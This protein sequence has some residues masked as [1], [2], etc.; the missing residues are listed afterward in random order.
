[1]TEKAPHPVLLAAILSLGAAISLGITRFAYGLLL[2]MMREDLG[3][4]YALAGAMNTANA[5]GYLLGA[6]GAPALL[7]RTGPARLLLW[8]AVLATLF[9]ASSGFF[10][11]PFPL[12]VQRLLAGVASAWVFVAGGLLVARLAARH[13][14]RSGWLLGLYYGG[15][16]WGIVA[17]SWLVPQALHRGGH[18]AHAWWWL[19]LSCA[20]ATGVLWQPLRRLHE[21]PAAAAASAHA[22]R[23]VPWQRYAPALA[24]YA[25][26]GIG[27]IGYMTFV[28][29]MLREH[30]VGE[31]GLTGFYACLG[32]A[33][34][35]SSRIWAG[36]LD[37]CREGQALALLNALLGLATIVPALTSHPLA[38]LLSGL[39]FG[40]VFL[41]VVASTTAWVRHNL[42]PVEWAHGITVFT[43]VFAVGQIVG[44]T[45]VG[46]IAD[47]HGGLARG[48]LVSAVV[49]W[50]GAAWALRQKPLAGAPSH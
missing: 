22:A 16:G 42:P 15:T 46:W 2:P 38:L 3:W 20:L 14:Q 30:G 6:L 12:L 25:C 31:Q 41:S 32:L 21:S 26:F 47:G 44:P 24:G 23:R 39:L 10:R 7:R 13:P 28:I 19:A 40:G 37:R 29:A 8:G 27:Y 4:T 18:W 45:W 9:M 11:D 43:V 49:L 33:V 5:V 50:L 48:L 17:S 1:M 35:A 36:L 34:V